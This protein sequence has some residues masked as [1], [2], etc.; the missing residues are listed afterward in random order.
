MNILNIYHVLCGHESI[1]KAIIETEIPY[2][3]ILLM[4]QLLLQSCV[5]I[6]LNCYSS[7]KKYYIIHRNHYFFGSSIS[8]VS[9]FTEKS[10]GVIGE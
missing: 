1:D 3:F 8:P 2:L 10:F 6:R 4:N 7:Y 9:I 5:K